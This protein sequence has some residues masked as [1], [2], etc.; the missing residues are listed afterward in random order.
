MAN[1]TQKKQLIAILGGAAGICLLA[2]G[3]V[4]HA[5]G[6]IEELNRQVEEKRQAI[7]AAETKIAQIPNLEKDVIILR[8]NLDEYVKILPDS[9][10]LNAFVR[11]L[12]QFERQSGILGTGLIKKNAR[13]DKSKNRFA[14][15]EYTYEMTATLWQFLKFIN[16][17]ENYERFVSI[18][19][20]SITAGG[21]G[22]N[23]DTRDGDVVHTVKLALQTY[24][25][26]GKA[27]GKEV[28][29]PDYSAQREALREEIW[30]RMQAIKIEKYEH[31]GHQGRRD[32]FVDPRERGDQRTDGP[33]PAE[34]RALVDKYVT[35]VSRLREMLQRM[36]KP[37]T[38]L[39][40]QYALEKGLREGL[41]KLSGEV[42][43][44]E[45][46]LSYAPFRLRWAKEVVQPLEDLRTQ[47]QDVAKVEPKRVDPFLPKAD[48]EQLVADMQRECGNGQLED[49]KNRYESV[50]NRL[51]V[52]STDP[53]YELAVAAKA[54]H[55]K[56]STAID[57][58]GM[59][60]RIQGVVVNRGGRS[61]VLMNGE[62][63]EEG[64]YVSDDLLV[65]LVEEE[66]VWFVFRGLTLVRTM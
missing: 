45:T 1:W 26:N 34:Q 59:D 27:A 6:Q 63:Y 35:E 47:V 65:K 50:A 41:E 3:G 30:K 53:R 9:K 28:E 14:A 52:P 38:T 44:D 24:T 54:W 4:Y 55:H 39:F 51:G 5:Q 56:A 37:D 57:F 22:K 49:A 62:T 13:A 2:A 46:R 20:F 17:I 19:D 58:K 42:N 8:E 25:Y 31:R 64:D 48:M 10:E 7:A 36:R 33:S 32:I 18:T 60:L 23:D 16:L 12:Q 40:E 29:I 66:Q 21:K 11:M 43:V 61:G 15:I